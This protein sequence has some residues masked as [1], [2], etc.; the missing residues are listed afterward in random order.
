MLRKVKPANW[1]RWALAVEKSAA[2]PAVSLV[3]EVLWR[4][5]LG[6]GCESLVAFRA[7]LKLRGGPHVKSLR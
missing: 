7:L 6:G 1:W 4:R 2:A 3:V 5:R